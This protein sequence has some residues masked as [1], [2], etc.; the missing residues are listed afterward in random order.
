MT[1]STQEVRILCADDQKIV[2][3]TVKV[4]LE[5]LGL[6]VRCVES[7]RRCL[8]EFRRSTY[9]FVLVNYEMPDMGG[10]EVLDAL[11]DRMPPQALGLMSAYPE[12]KVFQ[13]IPRE[14]VG[15]FL[16][17]PFTAPALRKFL[18][19]RLPCLPPSLMVASHDSLALKLYEKM[20]AND[21]QL[22]TYARPSD[23]LEAARNSVKAVVILDL[24]GDSVPPEAD[25]LRSE[26]I[27]VILLCGERVPPSRFEKYGEVISYPVQKGA[28]VDKVRRAMQS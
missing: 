25:L 20:L 9:D 24:P 13:R 27:P 19:S 21:F 16:G 18:R 17:K 11:A 28:L 7:G 14:L 5:Q 12:G 26:E 15:G 8:E 1:S 22:G 3:D 2:R 23:A 4:L 6:V 10:G